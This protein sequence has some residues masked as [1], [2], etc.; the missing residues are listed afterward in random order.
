MILFIFFLS[1][2]LETF[3][4]LVSRMRIAPLARAH[5]A[6]ALKTKI[7]QKLLIGLAVT[8]RTCV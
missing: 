8:L 7:C 2:F 5:L 6:S 3:K 1:S 4:K